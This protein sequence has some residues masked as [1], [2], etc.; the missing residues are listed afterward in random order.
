MY[1]VCLQNKYMSKYL[2][3]TQE[4]C[5]KE[6]QRG[7][8]PMNQSIYG[9]AYILYLRRAAYHGGYVQ[10]Q[11]FAPCTKAATGNQLG[12]DQKSAGTV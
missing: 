7:M 6:E 3:N 9:I 12:V 2:Q 8:D 4:T 5:R 10:G 11:V 1:V